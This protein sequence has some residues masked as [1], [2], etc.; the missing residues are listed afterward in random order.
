MV[1]VVVVVVVVM[2]MM[3]GQLD[4]LHTGKEFLVSI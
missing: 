3:S 1:V 4:V 2:M